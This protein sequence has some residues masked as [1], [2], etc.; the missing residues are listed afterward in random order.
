MFVPAPIDKKFVPY[1][2]RRALKRNAPLFVGGRRGGGARVLPQNTCSY[3]NQ[4]CG[5]NNA[6]RCDDNLICM[7]PGS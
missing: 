1:N 6:W 5:P 4:P 2:A 3:A 7:P